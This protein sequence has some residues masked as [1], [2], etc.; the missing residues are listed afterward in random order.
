MLGCALRRNL[1]PAILRLRAT[2]LLCDPA[3]ENVWISSALA[4]PSSFE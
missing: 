1:E 4:A 3:L 2:T